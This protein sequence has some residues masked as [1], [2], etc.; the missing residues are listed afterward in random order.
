MKYPIIAFAGRKG[1]GKNTAAECVRVHLG[2]EVKEVAFADSLKEL[3]SDVFG[4]PASVLRGPSSLR[5]SHVL[6]DLWGEAAKTTAVRKIEHFLASLGYPHHDYYQNILDA[7]RQI[8]PQWT[9]RQVLQ[10][11]GTD[12]LRDKVDKDIWV[13]AGL[14]R[15]QHLLTT[16]A[17][18]VVITDVRFPNE[19]LALNAAGATTALIVGYDDPPLNEHESEKSLD[20]CPEWWFDRVIVNDGSLD[21][22]KISIYNFVDECFLGDRYE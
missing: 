3:C 8:T 19:L 22:F 16:S 21:Y 20:R 17:S 2:N 7:V 14:K 18:L 12:L 6:G 5:D 10:F 9:A 4:I 15:A 13:N 1:V 11:I